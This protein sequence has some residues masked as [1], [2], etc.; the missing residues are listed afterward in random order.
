MNNSDTNL[1]YEIVV[2]DEKGIIEKYF[3]NPL[4]WFAEFTTGVLIS[5]KKDLKLTG[6]RVLQGLIKADLWNTF[7]KELNSY[8]MKGKI[9][10]DFYKKRGNKI[11]LNELFTYLDNN[12]TPDEVVFDAMKSIFFTSL[13]SDAEKKVVRAYQ[14][15]RVLKTLSSVEILLIKESYL[16]YIGKKPKIDYT[17]HSNSVTV[18]VEVLSERTS[19]PYDIVNVSRLNY[20][21]LTPSPKITLFDPE[22]LTTKGLSRLGIEIGEFIYNKD[23]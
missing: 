7:L 12:N 3:Q 18:W 1:P 15:L 10:D 16:V 20:S 22:N 21:S 11:N 4:L 14:L 8:R 6:G 2:K 13:S 23:L 17:R 5:D 19:L 9:Q